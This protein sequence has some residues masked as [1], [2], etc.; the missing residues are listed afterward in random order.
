MVTLLLAVAFHDPVFVTGT[1]T[2]SKISLATELRDEGF[3]DRAR[4]SWSPS[5]GVRL[6]ASLP[7][8]SESDR[9]TK[10][11]GFGDATVEMRAVIREGD[12]TRVALDGVLSL[13]TGAS[14]GHLAPGSGSTDFVG[15]IAAAWSRSRVLLQVGAR[16]KLATES[17]RDSVS[18]EGAAGTW[19]MHSEQTEVLL[20]LE[21]EAIRLGPERREGAE[22]L[23]A[24]AERTVS[25]APS[26]AI[27][28]SRMRLKGGVLIPVSTTARTPPWRVGIAL[29]VSR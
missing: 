10:R 5:D 26:L 24:R 27:R 17:G 9:V 7:F 18:L 20:L 23:F 8:R 21:G 19:L 2:S 11:A 12:S 4:L 3:E 15:G 16:G 6:S 25:L 14:Q 13:P 1:E 28:V 22:V 29:E